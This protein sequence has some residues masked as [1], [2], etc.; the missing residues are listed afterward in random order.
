MSYLICQF[1]S[2]FPWY[3]S[4]SDMIPTTS[5]LSPLTRTQE[6]LL[7]WDPLAD[8]QAEREALPSVLFKSVATRPTGASEQRAYA[9]V[10]LPEMPD[11]CF[12][13]TERYHAFVVPAA[14]RNP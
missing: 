8:S 7:D 3:G 13:R 1:V 4:D 14:C 2:E 9:S 12:T 11:F 10:S 6:S 5:Q